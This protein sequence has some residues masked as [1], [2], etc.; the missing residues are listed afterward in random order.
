MIIAGTLLLTDRQDAPRLAEGWLRIDGDRI[1]EVRRGACPHT[2]DLGGDDALILPGLIDAHV[3]LPQF[4]SIGI[5]SDDLLEWLGRAVY[6]AEAKWE[7]AAFAAEMTRRAARE[8]LS[9]GTT[10]IGAYATVHHAAAAAAIN[11]LSGMGLRAM[12]G[13]VLMDRDA[14]GELLRPAGRLLREVAATE[15]AGRVEVAVTPRFAVTC[16]EELLRG[17]GELARARG[18]A[19][20]THLAETREE[21]ARI[22]ERWGAFSYTKIYELAGIL[23]P[24]TV[25]GHGIWIDDVDRSALAGAGSVVA[26]CPGANLFLRAGAMDRRAALR[27][28]VR[29]A[30]GSDVAAGPDVSMVRVAR[31]MI[32]TAKR[33]GHDPPSAGECW[34]QITAGNAAAMG[35]GSCGRLAPGFEADVVVAR[36]GVAWRGH[37]DPLSVLLYAWDSRWIERVIVGGREG[38]AAGSA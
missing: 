31:G 24:R 16:S 30:L 8:M 15:G 27:A 6:P 23:T 33:L 25:L 12:V 2:T 19:V 11:V 37:P 26:H 28:G 29:L 38:Y 9:H 3:H 1:A 35:W 32:E 20:Q 14:P 13:Q 22:R 18:L 10:G 34:R 4:D 7:D 5:E 36:P 17:A 21:C